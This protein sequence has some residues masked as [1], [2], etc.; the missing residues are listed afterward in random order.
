MNFI[1]KNRQKRNQLLIAV[2]AFILALAGLGFG[3]IR[4][5]YNKL[6]TVKKETV[7]TES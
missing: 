6:S 4:P 1:P 2:A 5:Q 7:D 3:V